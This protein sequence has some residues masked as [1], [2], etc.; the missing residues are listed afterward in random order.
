MSFDA[1]SEILRTAA[2]CFSG[3]TDAADGQ[4][5]NTGKCDD[6]PSVEASCTGVVQALKRLQRD[7]LA[8]FHHLLVVI[9]A[10]GDL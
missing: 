10:D 8:L 3:G 4:I 2:V 5:R 1:L 6:F 7:D 9:V